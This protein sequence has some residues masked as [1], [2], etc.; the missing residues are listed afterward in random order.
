MAL[1]YNFSRLLSILGLDRF[2]AYL[3]KLYPHGA[4]RL[5]YALYR[6]R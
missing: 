6:L 5:L 4:V 3:A 2:P 1:C